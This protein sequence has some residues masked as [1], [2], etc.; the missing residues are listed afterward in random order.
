MRIQSILSTLLPVL[1]G[2]AILTI[3]SAIQKMFMHY[4]LYPASFMLPAIAGGIGGFLYH[5]RLEWKLKH[6]R[7]AERY[8]KHLESILETSQC[9][10]IIIDSKTAAIESINPAAQELFGYSETEIIGKKCSDYLCNSS[11]DKCPIHQQNIAE[12]IIEQDVLNTKGLQIPIIRKTKKVNVNAHAHI[13]VSVMDISPIVEKEEKLREANDRVRVADRLKTEFLTNVGHE[14]R[15]PLNA[16]IGISDLLT[17]YDLSDEILDDIHLIKQ[18][19][20]A[21]LK[22]MENIMD[23]AML[24]SGNLALK[25]Y[26]FDIYQSLDYTSEIYKQKADSEGLAF[27]KNIDSC[28]GIQFVGDQTAFTKVIHNLLDN[29]VKF[30]QAGRVAIETHIISDPRMIHIQISDTGMGV[31]ENQQEFIFDAF[32]QVDGSF[33]RKHEGT[34]MGLAVVE[35][36]V[37]KMGGTIEIESMPDQGSTFHIRLPV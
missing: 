19:G 31:P 2:S 28:K 10:I 20:K 34:G 25:S 4:P 22:T 1:A 18:S 11:P 37:Q 32:Y 15:T 30:T 16:I 26:P 24:K 7:N 33:T 5:L 21:L 27:H 17:G 23:Y 8:N 13:V 36:Y 3:L 12:D 9:G 6:L 14:I 29:A 35:F